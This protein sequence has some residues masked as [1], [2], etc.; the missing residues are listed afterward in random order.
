MVVVWEKTSVPRRNGSGYIFDSTHI[1]VWSRFFI[2]FQYNRSL[3]VVYSINRKTLDQHAGYPRPWDSRAKYW[4]RGT[5]LQ[6]MY[7]CDISVIHFNYPNSELLLRILG[8]NMFSALD[9]NWGRGTDFDDCWELVNL[10][11]ACLRYLFHLIIT[12]MIRS[13]INKCHI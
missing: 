3:W 13:E 12:Q 7:V 11:A 4:E 2:A 10:A 8:F 1:Y 9:S 5:D 6:T